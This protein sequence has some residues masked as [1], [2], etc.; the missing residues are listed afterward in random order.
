MRIRFCRIRFDAST[1]C[2]Y[3]LFV[4]V[5][6]RLDYVVEGFDFCGA[7][8]A[9]LDVGTGRWYLVGTDSVILAPL[10]LKKN[11]KTDLCFERTSEVPVKY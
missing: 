8:V 1:Q 4:A 10:I 3:L 7:F 11:P 2:P 5:W 6:F 9:F